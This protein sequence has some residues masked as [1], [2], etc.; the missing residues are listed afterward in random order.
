MLPRG[1]VGGS[2][3]LPP[4][5]QPKSRKPKKGASVSGADRLGTT[6]S[7]GSSRAGNSGGAG[8]SALSSTEGAVSGQGGKA[9][10]GGAEAAMVG[11]VFS[12]GDVSVITR[13]VARGLYRNF[14]LY[15]V[16]FEQEARTRTEVWHVQVETPLEPPPLREAET[17]GG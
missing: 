17:I 1:V 2:P 9:E 14:A 12:V 16:C 3:A 4:P 10:A 15:R 6:S 8:V 5:D 11:P 7:G 13:F